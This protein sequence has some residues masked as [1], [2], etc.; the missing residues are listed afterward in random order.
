[1]GGDEE[2]RE[3]AR[4]R[5][6]APVRLQLEGGRELE[7][8]YTANVSEGGMFVAVESPPPV[9][10][11]VRFEIDLGPEAGT[12]S[13][14]GEVAWIRVRWESTDRPIGMGIQFRHLADPDRERL[15]RRVRAALAAGDSD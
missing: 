5:L 8:G 12:A 14:Y 4:A 13:G 7:S 3:T 15:A 6:E 9:G 1:M 2:Q 11:L 10:I